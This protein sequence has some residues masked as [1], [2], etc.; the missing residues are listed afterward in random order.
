MSLVQCIEPPEWTYRTSESIDIAKGKDAIIDFAR[1][2]VK[3]K[4]VKY[5]NVDAYVEKVVTKF[6]E[7]L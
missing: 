1:E 3:R 6:K 7:M 4:K 2:F 5:G